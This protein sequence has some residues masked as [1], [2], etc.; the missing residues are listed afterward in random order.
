MNII[1]FGA[2]GGIG[3]AVTSAGASV[4]LSAILYSI[5]FKKGNVN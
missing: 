1:V 3:S 2:T 4:F 5:S